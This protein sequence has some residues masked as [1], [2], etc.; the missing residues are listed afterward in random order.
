[1]PLGIIAGRWLW[2]RF[3]EAI[4]VAPKPSVPAASIV[5]VAIVALVLANLVAAIPG[6][7]A[8]RTPAALLLQG[9]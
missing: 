6:R 1:V 7:R 8:A 4:H 3:A 9:E 2:T 5:L